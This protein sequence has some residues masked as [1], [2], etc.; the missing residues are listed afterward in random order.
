MSKGA[1]ESPIDAISI[2]ISEKNFMVVK[3]FE[4]KTESKILKNIRKF[5]LIFFR[6]LQSNSTGSYYM[7]NKEEESRFLEQETDWYFSM[8]F[9]SYRRINDKK[10]LILPKFW[11]SFSFCRSNPDHSFQDRWFFL[12][13]K[14]AQ[15]SAIDV[16]GIHNS[17]KILQVGQNSEKSAKKKC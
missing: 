1:Q 10:T 14:E 12:V 9:G 11:S 7:F 17:E 2:H 8:P 15:E 13:P 16:I 6:H 3:K 5:L 4:R